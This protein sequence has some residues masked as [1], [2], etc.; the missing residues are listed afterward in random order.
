MR[1]DISALSLLVVAGLLVTGCNKD[2]IITDDSS[3]RPEISL[4]NEYGVYTVKVGNELTIAPDFKNCDNAEITWV[5]DDKVVCRDTRYTAIWPERG[6]FYI[7]INAKN[8]YGS[9][10]EDIRVDVLDLVAP[11]I[12]LALPEG[13]LRVEQ[14]TEYIF[15]PDIQHSDE[16]GFR[17]EWFVDDNL[18]ST[19]MQYTFS[20]SETGTFNIKIVATND[21]GTDVKEF[22][23]QVIQAGSGGQIFFHGPSYYQPETTRYTFAG[24]QV[25]FAPVVTGFTNPEFQWCVN[26]EKYPGTS[27]MFVYTPETPGEYIVTVTASETASAT[28]RRRITRNIERAGA[29]ASASL[30]LICV[31]ATEAD[32]QRKPTG[33]SSPWSDK[34]YEFL[35]APGQFVDEFRKCATEQAACEKAQE[36]LSRHSYVTLGAFG[37]YIIVGFDHSIAA[38]AGYDFAVEGNAFIAEIGSSNEP[39]IVWVMQDVNGNGLP[40]DEWYELKGCEYTASNTRRNT[41]TTYFRPAGPGMN[42]EWRDADGT[43]G[44]VNFLSDYFP[45]TRVYFPTWLSASSY[46]LYGTRIRPNNTF[47]NDVYSNNPYAWGYADNVGSDAIDGASFGETGQFTGFRISNA[48]MADGQPVALKYIDFIKVQ[49]GVQAQYPRIGEVSTEVLSFRDLSM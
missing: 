38:S 40:D 26:G 25:V 14:G 30:K 1:R 21:D 33:A 36:K 8:S 23:V 9:A 27:A 32:R 7:T 42:V 2:D 22:P 13:G 17:I 34:V 20:S 24:R 47:V 10:S 41:F 15:A 43:T 48:V 5:M 37:G 46:T 35:P 39:G 3:K 29:G 49:C 4:D 28:P 45:A 44:A 31:D 12:S 19:E 11:V 16:P 6:E 18:V